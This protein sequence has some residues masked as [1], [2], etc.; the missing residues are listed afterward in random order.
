MSSPDPRRLISTLAAAA[1]L[2]TGLVAGVAATAPAPADA[3]V[4]TSHHRGYLLKAGPHLKRG[5]EWMGS[6]GVD[7]RPPSYCIDYGKATPR[8]I[9]WKDVRS[10]PGWSAATTARISYVLSRWGTTSSNTQAA[11][12][13][14]AVNLLIGDKRFAADWKASY[15]PQLAKKDRNVAP[16][17]SKMLAESNALRGPYKV[18]VKILKTA[19]VGGAAQARVTVTSATGRPLSGVGLSVKL[20]NAMPTATLPRRTASNG[21]A[22]VHFSPSAPGG[23]RVTATGSSIVQSGVIRLSTPASAALQRVVTSAATRVNSA[24]AAGF[25]STYPAQSLKASMVCTEDCYGAPPIDLSASNVSPRMKLQ[26]FLIVDGKVVPNKVLTLAPGRSGKMRVVVKDGNRISMAYR[27]QKGSGWS[28]F[29]P[30]GT[31]TVVDCPPSPDVDFTIDCPCDGE[32][33]AT[34]RDNNT[35]RYTHVLTIEIPGRATRTLTVPSKT[36]GSIPKLTW[37]RGATVTVW[38]QSQ[39]AG[40]NVGK[41]IK[42]TTVN[43]G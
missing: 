36:V 12:V 5:T 23:V 15:A 20:T 26:V 9:G 29:Q 41:K 28:G 18:G 34:L 1:L 2:S 35:T 30:Y 22:I 31:T 4:G 37:E 6:F 38:N 43:F 16:L 14:A 8:A 7:G 13:N 17:A 3:A 19:R 33:D 25:N 42:V 11:A 32:I 27:W 10:M 21:Q 24:A 39:L 40:K